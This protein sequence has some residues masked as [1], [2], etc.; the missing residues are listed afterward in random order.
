MVFIN[1]DDTFFEDLGNDFKEAFYE[2]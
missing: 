1:D 2:I